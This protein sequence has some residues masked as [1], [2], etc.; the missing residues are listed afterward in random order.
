MRAYTGIAAL[1]LVLAGCGAA[2]EEVD[3]TTSPRI[4]G[5]AGSATTT[6]SPQRS[7]TSV[8]GDAL[9]AGLPQDAYQRR[10]ESLQ[11]VYEVA[12]P[13]VTC[14]KLPTQEFDSWHIGCEHDQATAVAL[15]VF[16]EEYIPGAAVSFS[17]DGA[18]ICS[19][20]TYFI[21]ALGS[22]DMEELSE[23]FGCRVWTD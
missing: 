17:R 5:D 15:V 18:Q 6:D 9:L 4:D 7:D 2:G 3:A 12:N 22:V 21:A 1:C 8:D 11:K 16:D 14:S 10:A 20:R 19:G 23:V 13:D